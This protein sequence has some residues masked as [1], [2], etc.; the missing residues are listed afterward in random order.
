MKNM[1]LALMSFFAVSTESNAVPLS[2]ELIVLH[3]VTTAEMNGIVSPTVGSIVFNT[4]DNEIYERNV[5]AWRKISSDGSETKVLSGECVDI[6]GQGTTANPYIA[7]KSTPGK[8]QATSGLVCKQLYD[9]GCAMSSGQYW[10]NPDG[11]STTNA[12]EV[13]CDMTTQAGGWTKIEY[14]ADFPH[15]QHFNGDRNSWLRSNFTLNL[16]TTQINNI[17]AVSTEGR[18]RYVSSC[19]GVVQYLFGARDYSDAFG[20][21]F[22]NDDE[23]VFG[24]QRYKNTNI[25]VTQDGCV[26]NNSTLQFTIFE[27][28]DIRVPVINVHSRDNGSNGDKFGSVLTNNPAWLR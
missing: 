3:N 22:Q 4:D 17:R 20:F 26:V 13:Y 5:T 14:S 11:G 10:I 27:I 24:Q 23:T 25:T 15:I 8:T 19:Q 18:Q 28:N 16:S 21:R 1:I 12:F 7:T 9:T 6:T 2:D